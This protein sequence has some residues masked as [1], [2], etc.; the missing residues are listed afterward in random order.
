MQRLC[1]FQ[2]ILLQRVILN[3][4]IKTIT[5]HNTFV[6]LPGDICSTNI[7]HGVT[8]GKCLLKLGYYFISCA[9]SPDQFAKAMEYMSIPLGLAPNI[10]VPGILLYCEQD[11]SSGGQEAA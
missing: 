1:T 2:R 4:G 6:I 3:V 11:I 10:F 7:F 8:G 5:R 9:L